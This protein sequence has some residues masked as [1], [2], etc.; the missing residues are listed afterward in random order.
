MHEQ[1]KTFREAFN[2]PTEKQRT[3]Q[4]NAAL[5]LYFTLLA[6]ELNGA[7][8]NLKT[9]LENIRMDIPVTPVSVKENIWKPIMK[10]MLGKESTTEMNR[11]DITTIWEALN[12][13][14]GTRLGVQVDFPSQEQTTSYLESLKKS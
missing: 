7:G 10:Q 5:H 1:E 4:Q 6:E 8:Y 12:L 14:F 11:T 3:A 2:M 13:A 9:V